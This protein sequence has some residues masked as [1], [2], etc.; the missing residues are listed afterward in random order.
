M[1]GMRVH[2]RAYVRFR[3]GRLESVCPHTRRWPY[4]YQFD[5]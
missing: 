1:N 5:F 4:Q 3:Y 2:V